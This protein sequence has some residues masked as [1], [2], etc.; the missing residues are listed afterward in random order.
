VLLPD[1][2]VLVGGHAPLGSYYLNNR[3]GDVTHAAGGSDPQPDPSF[4]I[5]SPP[6]L[7]Y[8][9]RPVITD[10]PSSI[11]YGQTMR[12]GVTDPASVDSV[13][14]VR[15]TAITHLTDGDQ[16]TVDLPVISRDATSVTVRTPPRAAVAPV[17]PY[18]LFVN[19]KTP[20]GLT[21]S[22]SRQVF[23]GRPAPAQATAALSPASV[24]APAQVLLDD[25]S[26]TPTMGG[27]AAAATAT[28]APVWAVRRRSRTLG[29]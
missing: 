17:G 2:R 3:V 13:V 24:V 14:V 7:F 1:G 22:V 25:S 12:I 21:P 28:A 11:P 20:K 16:R 9:P 5:F 23:V 27:L 10:A 18:M 26:R 6:N 19:K 4:E 8:G 15:N 29:G